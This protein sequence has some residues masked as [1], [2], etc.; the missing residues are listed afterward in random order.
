MKKIFFGIGLLATVYAQAATTGVVPADGVFKFTFGVTRTTEGFAVPASAV[1]D[2]G[3]EY[4]NTAGATFTYGFL[5]TMADSYKKDVPWSLPAVA[6]AIDGFQVVEGQRIVLHNV[7]GKGVTG[8]KKAEYLPARASAYEGRYPIRFAMSAEKGAYYA[9]TCT[10]A[11]ASSVAQ[12]DVTLFSERCHIQAHH[13]TLAPNETRTFAWSVELSPNVFK[14]NG[15]YVDDAINVVV[16]GENAALKSLT[17][18]KQSQVAG[19]IRGEATAQMNV[20]RTMWLCDDSTGTDQ[21]C[22]IPYF[23]L[24]NFSGVG[25]GLSRW[26]PANLSIRNQGEGGL[27]TND[28]AHRKSC[29]LKPGD[30]LY[31][32]YGHNESGISSF[33]NN[34]ERYFQDANEAGANLI[35][36]SPVERRTKWNAETSTWGR[37]LEG[38]ALAGEAWVNDKIAKGASNVAFIDLNRRYNDWMN[39]ELQRIHRINPAVTPNG[40]ISY[41]YRSGKGAHVDNTHIN[42][43]GTDQAAYWVWYD[44]LARVAAG[45]AAGATRAQRVQA[46]VLKGITKGYQATV[47][48]D[49]AEKNLPWQV[50]DE[51]VKAGGV[52]NDYWDAAVTVGSP[53]AHDAVISDIAATANEDGSVTLSGVTMRI[54]NP[55]NYYKAV[56][57]VV[58]ADGVS[59][60]RY[61]SYYNYDVGGAGMSSGDCVTPNAP[62]WLTSDKDK[63]K[64]TAADCQTITIPAGA[65]AFAWI[66]EADAGT[67]QVGKKAPCSAKYPILWWSR[68]ILDDTC[69]TDGDWKTLTQAV[70]ETKVVDGARWF[71]STGA[72]EENRKK[73]FGL[74]RALGAGVAKGC[75]RISFKTKLDAG[76]LS[77][78][79]GDAIKTTFMLFKRSETLLSLNGKSVT[80]YQSL[81]PLVTLSGDTPQ[82][83]INQGR[84]VDVDLI[85]DRDKAKAWM[86]VGGSDYVAWADD[87]STSGSFSGRTWKYIGVTMPGKQSSYG[88]IDDVRILKLA[89]VPSGVAR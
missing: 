62:G 87:E 85:V 33:T 40:A 16:V 29:R 36:V 2:A 82:A 17:V 63:A 45:E 19:K 32:Q 13:L 56:V 77:V 52:P 60:N 22:S 34:L 54:L 64:V 11:N 43:A 55:G 30:Y 41:Y 69:E 18:V 46:A 28:N 50:T 78:K 25:S 84:W 5:G 7:E 14:R 72:N 12:A 35:I 1:F 44:A 74:Y 37:S 73:N 81:Q 67:W 15:T 61:Y 47:G 75:Y 65:K 71:M 6:K 48:L 57:E 58:S 20:G 79:L 38:Y 39:A 21:A 89:A 42:N 26:A 10:V 27:A 83:Q 80:G 8:P 9:V 49:S 68:V 86:S 59:T 24:Q 70:S 66:A 76:A 53:Y 23:S 51:I 3:R 4:K 88:C 31:V